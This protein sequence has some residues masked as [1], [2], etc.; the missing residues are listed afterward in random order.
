M[1]PHRH[2]RE[3]GFTLIELLVIML[4][5]GS[6]V[7][8]FYR[9]L[10]EG[11]NKGI[12]SPEQSQALR[13]AR[14]AF[15]YLDQD[16]NHARNILPRMGSHVTGDESLIVETVSFEERRRLLRNGD[17]FESMR[18]EEHVVHYHMKNGELVRDVYR[19]GSHQS[20]LV[21]LGNL[22]SL[23]F[24]YGNERPEESPWVQLTLRP[25]SGLRTL[26]AVGEV[27]RVFKTG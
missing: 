4:I 25:Q 21:L 10:H 23:K 12:A 16:L 1:T 7:P 15:R 20:T 13:D 5:L 11:V 8:T 18:G 6:L 19:N 17:L 9:F 27:R 14:V 26:N 3:N 22:D 2:A 24:E